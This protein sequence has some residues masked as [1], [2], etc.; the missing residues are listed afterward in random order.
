M[1]A[2]APASAGTPSFE[3]ARD[4][5]LYCLQQHIGLIP[6]GG[7]GLLRRAVYWSLVSR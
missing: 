7:P 1:N 2:S 4:G 3:L 6:R 5:T